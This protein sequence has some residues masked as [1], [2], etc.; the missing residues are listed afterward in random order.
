MSQVHDLGFEKFEL[1]ATESNDILLS[2]LKETVQVC[3]G[4]VGCWP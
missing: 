3:E 2:L 4:Q 1:L